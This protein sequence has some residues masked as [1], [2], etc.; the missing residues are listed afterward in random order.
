MFCRRD[1]SRLVKTAVPVL[2]MCSFLLGAVGCMEAPTRGWSGPLV[3]DNVLFVGTLEGK[4]VA[5]DLLTVSAGRPAVYWDEKVVAPTGGGFGCTPYLSRAMGVYGTPIVKDGRVY[6]GTYDG[7]VLFLPVDGRTISRAPFKAEG[8]IVGS[9]IIYQDMLFVGSSDGYLYA[10][11]LDLNLKW[12]F[13]THD[14]IW[15][16]PAAADGVVYIGSGDQRLYAIDAESG[17][18]IWRFEATGAIMSNPL[19]YEGK[20]YIGAC[21]RRFYAINMAT[22]EDRL[23][24][25]AREAGTAA[26]LVEYSAVFA[27]AGNWFWT[28]AT[29]HEGEIWVGSL[30]HKMYVLDAEDLGK[31]WE[32]ETG[33]MIY[34]PPVIVNGLVIFGSQDGKLYGVDPATRNVEVLY[35]PNVDDR[36]PILAPIFADPHNSVIY[37]HAQNGEHT[38]YAFKVD[39][40]EILWHF[41]TDRI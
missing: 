21:D 6:V 7:S 13:K 23:H 3:S 10:L 28:T 11:D 26:S 27:E 38:L 37:F 4:V 25:L 40:K 30:D 2:L 32:Y 1:R 19:I 35:S 18:E 14:K 24:A 5:L 20:V 12:K 8:A 29:A 22:E 34:S 41:R 31:L 36:A 17:T 16:T 33:G 9:P 15:S 39:T